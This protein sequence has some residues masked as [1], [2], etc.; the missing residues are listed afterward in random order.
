MREP[1][2]RRTDA[3]DPNPSKCNTRIPLAQD[4]GRV[5]TG[6]IFGFFLLSQ[7]TRG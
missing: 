1:V 2:L 3:K 7:Q 6:S 5:V 4:Q